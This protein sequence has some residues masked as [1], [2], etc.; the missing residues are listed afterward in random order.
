M[1]IFSQLSAP[2]TSARRIDKNQA[3]YLVCILGHLKLRRPPAVAAESTESDSFNES[4][5]R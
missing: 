4:N 5:S 2:Q 3:D 1:S